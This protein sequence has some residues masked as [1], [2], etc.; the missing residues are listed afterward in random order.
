MSETRPAVVGVGNILMGDDGVGPKVIELLRDRGAD[1]RAELIDAGLAIGDVMCDLDPKQPLVIVDAVRGGNAPGSIYRLD[2]SQIDARTAS[3]GAA[4]SLH[5]VNVL[6]ALHL[7]ALTGRVF[8]D[9]TIFGVEPV[10][11]AGGQALSPAVAE[12][13]RKVAEMISACLDRRAQSKQE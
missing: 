4:L 13:A 11:V 7:E 8:R 2:P 1:E 9:V 5:E 12:A 3:L 6:P 10:G